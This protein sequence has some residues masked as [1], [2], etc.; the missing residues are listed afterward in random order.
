MKMI[1]LT[2]QETQ[3]L[4]ELLKNSND[5]R[6]KGIVKKLNATS[7]YLL[8]LHA[9]D[10][11]FGRKVLKPKYRLIWR[12]IVYGTIIVLFVKYVLFP[13]FEFWDMVVRYLDFL[14]WG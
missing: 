7:W 8:V 6:C 1:N 10:G 14:V 11:R 2:K 13:A 3:Y 4:I 5:S 12:I 9:I